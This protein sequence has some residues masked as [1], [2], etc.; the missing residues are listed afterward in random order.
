MSNFIF[1]YRVERNRLQPKES[2][3]NFGDD[4][5]EETRW[6]SE[7]QAP[8]D[9]LE[10]LQYVKH[11]AEDVG[12]ELLSHMVENKSA[13]SINGVMYGYEEIKHIIED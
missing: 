8:E 10:L 11:N 7:G 12:R 13:I 5:S 9:D 4:Y 6:V 3:Y 2:G 1:L